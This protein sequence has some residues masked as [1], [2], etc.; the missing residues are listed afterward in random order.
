MEN[1]SSWMNS[2]QDET[3]RITNNLNSFYSFFNTEY[4]R[5]IISLPIILLLAW[6]FYK[7][8]NNSFKENSWFALYTWG[9][10]SLL[11]IPIILFLYLGMDVALFIPIAYAIIVLYWTWASTKFYNLKFGKALTV[12]IL[13]QVAY[14]LT[15][16][17]TSTLLPKAIRLFTD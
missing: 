9:H 17:I 8:Y 1:L 10:A 2:P 13:M 7:R 5:E 4:G 16:G 6:L 15:I 3:D 11:T 14:V 12:R